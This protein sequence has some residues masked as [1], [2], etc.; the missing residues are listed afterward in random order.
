MNGDMVRESHLKIFWLFSTLSY[1][2]S[3]LEFEFWINFDHQAK[4][5][6]L[7]QFFC[8]KKK[9]KSQQIENYTNGGKERESPPYDFLILFNAILCK[10]TPRIR[11]LN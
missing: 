4:L 2:K 8:K 6:V 3:P 10:I 9:K 1:V 5:T 7:S 11:I